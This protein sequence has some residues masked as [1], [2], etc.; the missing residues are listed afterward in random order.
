MRIF[1]LIAAGQTMPATLSQKAPM[2]AKF[3]SD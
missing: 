1:V 2:A 3:A